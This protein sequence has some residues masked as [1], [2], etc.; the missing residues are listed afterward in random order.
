MLDSRSK[1]LLKTLIERYISDGQPVG[2]RTLSRFAGLDLSAATVRN[3]MADL[4]ELGLISS[5]HT[6][7]GRVPTPR[8]LRLFV[9][10]L[11]TIQPLES[12]EAAELA[13]NLQADQPQKVLASAANLLSSMSHFAGV[14]FTPKRQPTFRQIEF[15][16][17]ADR[18]LLMIIVTPQGDIENRVL[19]MEREYHANELVEAANYINGHF[20]GLTFDEIQAKLQIELAHLGNSIANLTRQ[21]VTVGGDTLLA[22][23]GAN[24]VVFSGQSRLFDVAEL[25]ENTKR[26]RE[27]FS[28]FERKSSLIQLL[29][30][31]NRASGVQIFIGGESELFPVDG[32]SVVTAP[33][34][35]DGKIVGTLG[36]VG[37]TRMAY[38]RVIP[39]V[40]ITA[41][42]VGSALT[43]QQN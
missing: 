32:M 36:V 33:Y 41:K 22:A 38:E 4:E 1:M 15:L 9:D 25:S 16:R 5:P 13:G 34:Q 8:G 43:Q 2:S 39:I 3:V 18:R 30:A 21:A 10:A 6:S 40:D 31:T 12:P 7:A 19:Q 24:E 27:L 35:V 23:Q 11:L 29:D 37:P 26:L 14:V 17:L 28:M 42:L 20:A